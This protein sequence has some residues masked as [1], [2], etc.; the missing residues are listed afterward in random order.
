MHEHCASDLCREIEIR[1]Y[2]GGLHGANGFYW[3]H[4]S[5]INGP[6]KTLHGTKAE[7][8]EEAR[9]AVETGGK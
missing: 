9:K 3:F 6:P 8:L 5:V 7:A 4:P 2:D 1:H